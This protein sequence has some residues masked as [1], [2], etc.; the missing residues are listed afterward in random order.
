MMALKDL[1]PGQRFRLDGE[2]VGKVLHVNAGSVTVDLGSKE[3][4]QIGE[5]SFQARRSRIVTLAR[6]TPAEAL[7]GARQGPA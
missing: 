6:E 1:R 7:G 2:R 4:V 3:H 5:R